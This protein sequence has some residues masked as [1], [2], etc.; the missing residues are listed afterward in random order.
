MDPTKIGHKKIK[1]QRE[2]LI[3]LAGEFRSMHAVYKKRK[4][5][6][7]N[8]SYRQIGPDWRFDLKGGDGEA[9]IC[10]YLTRDGVYT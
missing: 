2:V 7:T 5:R 3:F 10:V 6:R 9:K 4:V 8:T 1:V